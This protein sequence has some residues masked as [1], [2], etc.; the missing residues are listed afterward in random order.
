MDDASES[1]EGSGVS[2]LSFIS[3]DAVGTVVSL[4]GASGALLLRG[5]PSMI[6][7]GVSGVGAILLF[8]SE[9]TTSTNSLGYFVTLASW[10][11]LAWAGLT[12]Q[13]SIA[14][15]LSAFWFGIQADGRITI[16]AYKS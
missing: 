1:T 14:T 12:T 11:L 4:V 13:L 5:H 10:S 3:R 6:L 7:A 16:E 9:A 15:I 8:D 2:L